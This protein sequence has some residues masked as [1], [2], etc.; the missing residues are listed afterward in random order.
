MIRIITPLSQ[1]STSDTTI[2]IFVVVYSF[3]YQLLQG[4]VLTLPYNDV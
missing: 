4:R 2:Y 1:F 3:T